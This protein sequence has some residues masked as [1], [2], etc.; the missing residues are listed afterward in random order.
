MPMKKILLSLFFI[1]AAIMPSQALYVQTCS[2]RYYSSF[3]W[4]TT[5]YDVTVFFLTGGEMNEVTDTYEFDIY[6]VYAVFEWMGMT[7]I[8]KISDNLYCGSE[9]DQQCII[10]RFSSILEGHDQI[11]RKW[12]ICTR[13]YCS[14]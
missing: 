5:Y 7:I 8:V 12:K 4:S 14:W 1:I 11:G 10:A 2:V 6:K 3:G 13:G 9:T